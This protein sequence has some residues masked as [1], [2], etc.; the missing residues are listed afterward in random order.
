MPQGVRET[1][2]C[3]MPTCESSRLLPR[4]TQNL[5]LLAQTHKVV[6]LDLYFAGHF[7]L[8]NVGSFLGLFLPNDSDTEPAHCGACRLPL[9]LPAFRD[10]APGRDPITVHS[11]TCFLLLSLKS[12]APTWIGTTDH[13]KELQTYQ[14]LTTSLVFSSLT[15][16]SA[17]LC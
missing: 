12:S 10:G 11:L 3:T 17:E 8:I 5:T 1:V 2:T 6:F 4:V 14:I 13:G 16:R 9:P 15:K 7:S